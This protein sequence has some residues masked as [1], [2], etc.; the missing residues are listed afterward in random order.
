MKKFIFGAV[1]SLGLLVS[2]ALTQ[3]SGLTSTQVQA[4]LS[5][6]QSFGADS[7]TIANVNSA[8][9]GTSTGDGQKWCH[10]FSNDLTVGNSGDDVSALNQALASSGVDTTSNTSNFTENNA[11]DVVSFQARYGIRQTGYVGPLTRAKLNA[12]Y[13]CSAQ[14]V[15]PL[16]L[17]TVPTQPT[18]PVAAPTISYIT[19]TSAVAGD[20]VMIYGTNFGVSTYVMFDTWGVV[21]PNSGYPVN[22]AVAPGTTALA[23]T[24]P[25]NTS[26]G[27][28][29]IQVGNKGSSFGSS[30][31]V[32]LNVTAF[33]PFI[34]GT[35]AK[36]AGN[37]EVD[38]GGQVAI[39]GTNLAGD[40][41]TTAVFI[42]GIQATITQVGDTLLYA[43]VPSSLVVGQSYGMY[44][45]NSHGTSNTVMVKV[46]SNMNT[47]TSPT[48]TSISLPNVIAGVA[49]SITLYGSNF[50][51][52]LM[53]ALTGPGADT[54]VSPTFVS[55]DGTSMAFTFPST[56]TALGTYSVQVYNYG[57]RA[58]SA[59]NI[60]LIPSGPTTP[61]VNSFSINDN[62]QI[63]L[64]AQNY[65]TITFRADCGSFVHVLRS[66]NG[67][68]LSYPTGSA[69]LCNAE[70]YFSKSSTDTNMGPGIVNQALWLWNAQGVVNG[71]TSFIGNGP[72]TNN[73]G[74]ATLFV[75]VCNTLGK[76]VQQSAV[77]HIYA[78]G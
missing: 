78:K 35:S 4:I 15:R 65:S 53:I 26:V 70:Q 56:I 64:S 77:V 10:T 74:A 47:P 45:S 24:V 30:N 6:L 17:P 63:S 37:F 59:I 1:L 31:G 67:S 8:L 69:S 32:S 62:Q 55:Q 36:A 16:P 42:G 66:P 58:Y 71:E 5:L 72:T 41:R 11:G 12:L 3:A 73:N 68:N 43:N 21:Y 28:H 49:T 18:V 38:A 51:P 13:G 7:S 14:P 9:G 25:L 57:I 76:C 44:V 29:T 33:A 61:I 2:P 60:A 40:S 22:V 50:N 48:I 54:S 39:S 52:T 46:L 75:N 20:T 27:S 23:F 19:P 34:T